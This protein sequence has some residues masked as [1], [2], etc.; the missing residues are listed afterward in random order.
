MEVSQRRVA[1][2][3]RP[4]LGAGKGENLSALWPSRD[5]GKNSSKYRGKVN[6]TKTS[7]ALGARDFGLAVEQMLIRV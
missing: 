2:L 5:L 6:Y 4:S 3:N 1:D 7:L